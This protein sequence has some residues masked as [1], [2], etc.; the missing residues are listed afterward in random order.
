MPFKKV[1]KIYYIYLYLYINK[2]LFLIKLNLKT[3][4]LNF[5]TKFR[6]KFKIRTK[7]KLKPMTIQKEG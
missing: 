2:C 1:I 6:T 3:P 5:R 4:K 7:F